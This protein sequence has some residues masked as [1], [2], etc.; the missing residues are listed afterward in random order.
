M[1]VFCDLQINLL[2]PMQMM[3]IR[4]VSLN[5]YFVQD[6]I[7]H[8]VLLLGQPEPCAKYTMGYLRLE[9]PDQANKYDFPWLFQTRPNVHLDN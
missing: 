1:P 9:Q 2:I 3:H 7:I 6:P 4:Y 8:V 5:Q